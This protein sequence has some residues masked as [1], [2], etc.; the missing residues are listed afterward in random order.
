MSIPGATVEAALRRRASP[1][2]Q[3]DA[4]FNSRA[5]GEARGAEG[6]GGDLQGA[7]FD[8]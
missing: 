5:G 4:V 6:N 1:V 8:I 7:V 3:T 2:A